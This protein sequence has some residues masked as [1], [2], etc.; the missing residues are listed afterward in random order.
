M[1]CPNLF[2]IRRLQAGIRETGSVPGFIPG[3]EWARLVIKHCT[4]PPFIDRED[5][6]SNPERGVREFQS[7]QSAPGGEAGGNL[8]DGDSKGQ[9]FQGVSET[10]GRG[11]CLGPWS[12]RGV[13]ARAT[14]EGSILPNCQGAVVKTV[15][16]SGG[17]RGR[18]VS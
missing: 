15:R 10:L 16:R 17:L 13:A 1:P 5:P 7:F 8:T 12:G 14:V 18:V 11:H 6:G 4:K 9:S 2:V 3:H